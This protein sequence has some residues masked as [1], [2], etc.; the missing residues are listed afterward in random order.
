MFVINLQ[1]I[2]AFALFA[3]FGIFKLTTK[4]SSKNPSTS[5]WGDTFVN[6]TNYQFGGVFDLHPVFRD[7]RKIY[8]TNYSYT[9]RVL[10]QK[11]KEILS[12]VE[13]LHGLLEN[14]DFFNQSPV[15]LLDNLP[16]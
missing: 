11:L 12:E 16:T 3:T 4:I 7:R 13:Y 6:A 9:I 1:S 2:C 15:K 14:C 10:A 5:F 8:V